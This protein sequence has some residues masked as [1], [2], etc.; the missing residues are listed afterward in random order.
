MRMIAA[1]AWLTVA[2]GCEGEKGRSPEVGEEHA[3]APAPTNRVDI[4]ATVRRNLGITF[5][6]VERRAVESTLRVPGR[7]ELL[8]SAM[9]EYRAPLAGI[10]HLQVAQY[11]EVSE[12]TLL[13]ALDSAEWRSLQ[14][15]IAGAEAVVRQLEARLG[16]MGPI[17]ES[18]RR[19]EEAL[20]RKV[21]IWQE[22]LAQL[23]ELRAAGGGNASEFMQARDTLNAT[24]AELAEVIETEAELASR[25]VE[26]KAELDAA[27]SKVEL[28]LG[29]ASTLTGIPVKELRE[30]G[31]GGGDEARPR[32]MEIGRIE[33]RAHKS[34]IV[35]SIGVRD[36]AL[37]GASELILTTV[38]PEQVRFRARGLQA[39]IGRLK[40]GLAARIV[41]PAGGSI[42]MQESL[43]G[44][45]QI[46]LA[47]DADE[48]TVD[49]M[50]A[51]AERAE[52]AR[53]GVAAHLEVTIEGGR[54]ELAIP[55]S[56]VA[57]DGV[58]SFIFR[59][60]PKNPDAAIRME[61]D[62][63]VSD[64][65]WVVIKSG[66]KEGDEVVVDGVYQLML[67]TAGSAPKG[68]HFHS[69]GTFHEGE[70]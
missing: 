52:W 16:A 50:V 47:A 39:D 45:L 32:W 9:H 53:A 8:Q 51:P 3:S 18:H 68:G 20:S 66:V 10:V 17:R 4:P 23:E 13:F 37:A 43:T 24:E 59:R 41:P 21:T 33:V 22:R 12:G 44:V 65:R 1:A 61:A 25:E 14:E 29:T 70:H 67:A 64:G 26:L 63:G 11:E 42:G 58:R 28:L 48:R 31:A 34:G 7:F 55:A 54:E 49:L 69:D 36:G 6:R 62:L 5:A 57:R 2:G 30:A 15:Q 35:D 60:D 19:H 56:A 40:N 27:R 38:Q 46:G